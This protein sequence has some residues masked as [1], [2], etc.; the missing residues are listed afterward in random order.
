[1]VIRVHT[2]KN[3]ITPSLAF[4]TRGVSVLMSMPGPAGIA[5][6]ATGFGLLV[7]CTHSCKFEPVL[8]Y[9]QAN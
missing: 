2:S 9:M 3:S 8:D 4:L 6:E 7:T 1:M 5:H